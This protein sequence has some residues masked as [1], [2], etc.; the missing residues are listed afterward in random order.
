VAAKGKKNAVVQ[1]APNTFESIVAK[2]KHSVIGSRQRGNTVNVSEA[3]RAVIESRKGSLL[4]KFQ[5]KDK[6]NAFVDERIG[7]KDTEMTNEQVMFERFH[8]ERTQGMKSGKKGRFNLDGGS[9]GGEDS[10]TLTH[11]GRDVSELLNWGRT[12]DKGSDAEGG[13]G[14]DDSDDAANDAFLMFGAAGLGAR[15]RTA[16]RTRAATRRSWKR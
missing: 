8:R 9:C 5:A 15:R 16:R 4:V 10:E 3:R 14:G 7:E 11:L 1:R 13:G 12:V 2:Q 6:A